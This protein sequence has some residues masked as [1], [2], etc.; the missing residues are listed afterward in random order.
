MT[1]SEIRALV[2]DDLLP[3]WMW[4]L[5]YNATPTR[6]EGSF[7]DAK[8]HDLTPEVAEAALVGH[9][10]MELGK[11]P[12]W[13]PAIAEMEA[14]WFVEN[15]FVDRGIEDW[16]APSPLAALVAACRAVKA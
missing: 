15:V 1:N 4:W 14:T 11:R 3:E 10:V 5:P 13:V 9:L 8:G 2:S 6:S 16:A 12:D 7:V